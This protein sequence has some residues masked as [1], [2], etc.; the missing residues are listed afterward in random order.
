[1]V[2][3]LVMAPVDGDHVVLKNYTE[4]RMGSGWV[5]V[6]VARLPGKTVRVMGSFTLSG[7][8]TQFKVMAAELGPGACTVDLRDIVGADHLVPDN[9]FTDY[10]G[11]AQGDV[12][13]EDAGIG[14]L[15]FD[16]DPRKVEDGMPLGSG[17]G[18]FSGGA[19][20]GGIRFGVDMA[21]TGGGW[22]DTG[23]WPKGG[24]KDDWKRS[25]SLEKMGVLAVAAPWIAWPSSWKVKALVPNVATGTFVHY[26]IQKR[27]LKVRGPEASGEADTVVS[28]FLAI[29][30]GA[31]IDIKAAKWEVGWGLGDSIEVAECGVYELGKLFGLIRKAFEEL[32]QGVRDG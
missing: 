16:S 18:L 30:V 19:T 20:G 13:E 3:H 26:W 14:G 7:G 1:M 6:M 8:N 11:N 32:A 15:R 23:E 10:Y 4:D 27:G 22:T 28:V 21:G 17:G 25:F 24:W 9:G 29:G 5:Q 12:V 31:E 2:P